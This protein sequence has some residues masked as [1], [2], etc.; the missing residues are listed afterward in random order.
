MKSMS[1]NGRKGLI[2]WREYAIGFCAML[3]AV[4]ILMPVLVRADAYDGPFCYEDKSGTSAN[5]PDPSGIRGTCKIVQMKDIVSLDSIVQ[6]DYFLGGHGAICSESDRACDKYTKYSEELLLTSSSTIII[7]IKKPNDVP[8][9][10]AVFNKSFFLPLLLNQFKQNNLNYSESNFPSININVYEPNELNA[11]QASGYVSKDIK[12]DTLQEY[13]DY[14][15]G[16]RD[17]P[18]SYFM[19]TLSYQEYGKYI[20]GP[21]GDLAES[22]YAN[23]NQ[24]SGALTDKDLGISYEEYSKVSEAATV[25]V[26]DPLNSVT[27]YWVYS[28]INGKPTLSWQKTEYGMDDGTI[29]TVVPTISNVAATKNNV[30]STAS[31]TSATS[32]AQ[33]PVPAGKNIFQKIW[34]FIVSWFR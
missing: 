32:T 9:S 18:P 17:C 26:T 33:N 29:K 4:L 28:E 12:M 3:M 1:I 11:L 22:Q 19:N 14:Y 6:K 5:N 13:P 23:L 7:E 8:T 31:T 21:K 15:C 34:D 20:W 24:N 2:G 27:N 10:V 16:S 30:S 25:A